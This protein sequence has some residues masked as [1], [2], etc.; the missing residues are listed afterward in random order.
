MFL[1]YDPQEAP[2]KKYS[3][4]NARYLSRKKTTA[5]SGLLNH[6]SRHGQSL[7]ETNDESCN[8]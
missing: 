3:S 7:A 2:T 5:A 8:S 4:A 1:G 6:L